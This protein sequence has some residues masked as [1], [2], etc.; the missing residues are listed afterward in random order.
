MS[1]GQEPIK[2]IYIAGNGRSGSTLLAR[3]LGQFDNCISIGEFKHIWQRNLSEN[4]LCGCGEP[5]DACPFWQ[6]VFSEADI[7]Q[8]PD[9][10]KTMQAKVDR[11]RYLPNLLC[12]NR[13]FRQQIDEFGSIVEAIFRA[14]QKT[15]GR[16]V[17][18]DSSKEISRLF[19]YNALPQ[20][21]LYVIHLVRDS[22]GVAFSWQRKRVRPEITERVVYMHRYSAGTTAFRWLGWNLLIHGFSR[23]IN[24]KNLFLRYED[25][26][27]DPKTTLQQIVTKFG[28]EQ[29]DLS[30]VQGQQFVLTTEDHTVAGNPNR[31]QK[32]T[33]L[34]Q[35]DLEWRQAMKE[36]DQWVV[37]G[38]TWPLLLKYGYLGK[39]RPQ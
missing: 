17:I 30:F 25:L 32:G 16:Q 1:L 3:M 39:M 37:T 34:L 27:L 29:T 24:H 13:V 21:E 9:Q 38:L 11:M 7:K 2:V 35:L 10:L 14:I 26:I 22:R 33:M 19:L 8:D 4:Q 18:V 15:S 28:L 36:R 5:F 12:P 20:I 6:Q 31:F 23:M